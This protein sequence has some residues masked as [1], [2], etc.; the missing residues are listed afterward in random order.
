[1]PIITIS[2]GSYSKG[3]EIAELLANKLNYECI[4]RDIL[5][6]ASEE[7][8]IPEVKLIRALH[9][10]PSIL[11]RFSHGKER[12]VAYIKKALLE[13]VANGNAVYHG[14]A[15]HFLLEGISHVL[16]VRIISNFQ[17]RVHEEMKREN[18]TE[19][20]S[21]AILK[22]D[23]EERKKW[24]LY[25]YGVDTADANLYDVVLHIDQLSVNNAVEILSKVA[26]RKCFQPTNA[27][28]K[29][30]QE[31]LIAARA[32]AAL[33][34]IYPNINVNC[35][36]GI[37]YVN[38]EKNITDN[39]QITRNICEVLENIEGV[40]GIWTNLITDKHFD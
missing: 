5:L 38:F 19:D 32:K 12:Y 31:Y 17:S 15:G 4:S 23:D 24:G 6:E 35:K 36:E 39:G 28:I 30:F 27:S 40:K 33:V 18:I 34:E 11:D 1:M 22:K 14:L 13:H 21:Y 7:F 37:A 2:R 9:D 8:N 26:K 3:K 16:K 20:E 25:L 10:A 29:T